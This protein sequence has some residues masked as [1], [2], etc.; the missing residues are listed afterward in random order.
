M[1][2]SV[3]TEQIMQHETSMVNSVDPLGGSYYVEWLTSE[4]ERQAWDY[5]QKIEDM[6]GIVAALDSGWVHNEFRKAILEH[7]KKVASGETARV[8]V[9]KFRLDEEPYKVPVFRA[10]PGAPDVQI[11]KLRKVKKERDGAV[12]ARALQKVRESTTGDENVMPAVME[13]VKA[14]ATLGEIYDVWR[15]FYGVWQKPMSA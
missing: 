1:L 4:V 8:G 12:V 14:Q 11:E 7:E 13:A 15:D 6:G 10:N 9:N 3:R 5:I 2:L